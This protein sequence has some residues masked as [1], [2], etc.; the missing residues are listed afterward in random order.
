MC[1]KSLG[2]VLGKIS[3][4]KY[5]YKVAIE[6]IVPEL[7]VLGGQRE[8][9]KYMKEGI[10][11]FME[12]QGLEH[13]KNRQVVNSIKMEDE[14]WNFLEQKHQCQWSC[15]QEIIVQTSPCGLLHLIGIFD[16][17]KER[18]THVTMRKWRFIDG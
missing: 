14:T 16:D 1:V 2:K 15:E 18:L 17:K 4:E 3:L 10:R 13:F 8:Y 7:L 9:K 11:A 12:K 6:V 5:I